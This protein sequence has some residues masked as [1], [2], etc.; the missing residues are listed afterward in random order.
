MVA[1]E[2]ILSALGLV[3]AIAIARARPRSLTIWVFR[4][5]CQGLNEFNTRALKEFQFRDK[6]SIMGGTNM[7]LIVVIL[8][9]P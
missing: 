1:H 8:L 5:R 6:I 4:T 7:S 2:I 9:Q 3:I